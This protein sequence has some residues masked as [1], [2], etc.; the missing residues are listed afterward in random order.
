[1][2]RIFLVDDNAMIRSQLRTAL[3]K[4]PDWVVVGEAEDGRGAVEHW[5]EISPNLTVMDFV[6]P[7]MDGLEAGR[8]LSRQHPD[9]P[10]LMV[11]IDPSRQLEQEAKKAGI[12]GLCKKSDLRS[13]MAAVEAVLKGKTY[14]RL[15]PVA[16]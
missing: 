6:M 5:S 8:R 11:T 3:E 10:V 1:M 4:Q 2:V 16:A 13:L 7:E 12:R 9:T 14:F 15:I